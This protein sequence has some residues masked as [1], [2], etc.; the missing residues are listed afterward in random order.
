MRCI[1]LTLK[2]CPLVHV[3]LPKALKYLS[4]PW[5]HLTS[6]GSLLSTSGIQNI[7]SAW[8]CILA[9]AYFTQKQSKQKSFGKTNSNQEPDLPICKNP[10]SSFSCYDFRGN[11]GGQE[12][13]SERKVSHYRE[14][15]LL[16]IKISMPANSQQCF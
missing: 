2:C 15:C 9:V 1:Q 8:F 3:K 11:K 5:I 6:A 4:Y 12:H 14:Y 16:T 13:E 7:G 10:Q